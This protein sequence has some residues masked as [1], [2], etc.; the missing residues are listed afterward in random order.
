MRAKLIDEKFTKDSD[1][2]KDLKIGYKNYYDYAEKVLKKY[3][4]NPEDFTLFLYDVYRNFPVDGVLDQ[5]FEILEH[6]PLEYQVDY[7]SSNLYHFMVEEGVD[8]NEAIKEV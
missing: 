6:T 4:L 7:I 1:P 5:M 3:N 2:I 8:E